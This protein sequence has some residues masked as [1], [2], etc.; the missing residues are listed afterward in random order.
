MNDKLQKIQFRHYSKLQSK[1]HQVD[2]VF[3]FFFLA[4]R[5]YADELHQKEWVFYAIFKGELI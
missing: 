2:Q 1:L 3:F 5:G 4:K